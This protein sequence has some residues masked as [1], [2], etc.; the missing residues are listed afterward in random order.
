MMVKAMLGTGKFSMQMLTVLEGQLFSSTA[1]MKRV[2]VMTTVSLCQMCDTSSQGRI[3]KML[4]NWKD[5]AH[6]LPTA[7]TTLDLQQTLAY[8]FSVMS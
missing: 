6:L 3:C 2:S 8:S 7:V 1:S 5:L 4:H